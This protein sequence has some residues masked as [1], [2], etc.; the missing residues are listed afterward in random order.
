M[1]INEQS[2]V[3]VYGLNGEPFYISN[4]DKITSNYIE[5]LSTRFSKKTGKVLKQQPDNYGSCY[6]TPE[7]EVFAELKETVLF[8]D[9]S[10]KIEIFDCS[11]LQTIKYLKRYFNFRFS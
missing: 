9:I 3:I 4:V 10:S 8:K 11:N 1:D 7:S 6:K 2:I 5:V